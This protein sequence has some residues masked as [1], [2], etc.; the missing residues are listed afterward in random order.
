[1]PPKPP[2]PDDLT[3][4]D[5]RRITKELEAQLEAHADKREHIPFTPE[6][7][8]R[9]REHLGYLEEG[10]LMVHPRDLDRMR[11]TVT[12]ARTHDNPIVLRVPEYGT[13]TTLNPVIEKRRFD[14]NGK[15]GHQ[16]S[17]AKAAR[18]MRKKNR[19]R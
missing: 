18:A 7:E 1:M 13:N 9:I 14:P 4:D 8:A 10:P 3:V 11:E 12:A 19:R 5:I 16:R 2:R 6:E 17:R 15:L